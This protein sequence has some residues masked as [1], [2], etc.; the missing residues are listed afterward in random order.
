[1][2]PVLRIDR[3]GPIA[4]L[5]FDDPDRRNAMTR[6]MGEELAA[7]VATLAGDDAI[8]VLVLT[9]AGKAFSAGGDLGML[10]ELAERGVRQPVTGRQANRD[11]MRSFYGLFLSVRDLPFPTVAAINGAAIGAGL[12]VALAC[13]IRLAARDAKLGVNFT[14]VGIHPG[15]GGTWTLPRLVGPALAAEL[16]YSS[17]LFSGDEAAAMGIVNRA[18]ENDSLMGE[19]AQLAGQIAAGAPLAVRGIKRALAQSATSSLADQLDFEA[20]QQALC[21]ETEDTREGL[22]AARER[23]DP[24]FRG[25]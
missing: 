19:T 8:R 4:T 3:D 11:V 13:D 14:K 10:D 15:M 22:A 9:G 25:R 7:T 18:I 17:R 16:L 12:C 2:S 5:T 24:V 1:M 21:F 23:R 6:Q 20:Q